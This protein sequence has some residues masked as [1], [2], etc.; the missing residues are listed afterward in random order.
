MLF[1]CENKY[2]D[3]GSYTKINSKIQTTSHLGNSDA[4][5]QLLMILIS[6][7]RSIQFRKYEKSVSALNSFLFSLGKKIKLPNSHK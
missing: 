4:I 1:S 2:F 7:N 6:V 5:N 3:I